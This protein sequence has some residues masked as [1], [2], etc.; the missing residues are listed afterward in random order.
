MTQYRSL[1]VTGAIFGQS[2]VPVPGKAQSGPIRTA[3]EYR[4]SGPVIATGSAVAGTVAEGHRNAAQDVRQRLVMT[5]V[6]P[7]PRTEAAT[8]PAARTFLIT[9][10]P[11]CTECP[12]PEPPAQ[13]V[14]GRLVLSIHPIADPYGQQCEATPWGRRS[15]QRPQ[16][17]PE[18]ST[19][20]RHAERP[21]RHAELSTRA[22]R[23]ASA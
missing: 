1:N 16:P 12:V 5:C 18:A 7:R 6:A 13:L 20:R 3:E 11:S 9:I 14:T 10:N 19:A 17:F 23:A 21:G 4:R 15:I 8:A 22:R 2:D